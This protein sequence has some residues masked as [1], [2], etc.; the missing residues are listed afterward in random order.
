MVYIVDQEVENEEK[1]KFGKYWFMD[2]SRGGIGWGAFL[3]NCATTK[4][5]S[6]SS[7]SQLAAVAGIFS[8]NCK[9]SCSST[10]LFQDSCSATPLGITFVIGRKIFRHLV[11]FGSIFLCQILWQISLWGKKWKDKK[12]WSRLFRNLC[13]GF[14][15]SSLGLVSAASSYNLELPPL[16]KTW[17]ANNTKVSLELGQKEFWSRVIAQAITKYKCIL[18]RRSKE[19]PPNFLFLLNAH[20]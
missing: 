14:C 8:S 18:V 19:S 1:E 13:P 7:S 2:R 4:P 20:F 15:P 6:R 3:Q 9:Q 10:R 17:T 5:L 16:N 11:F 12:C